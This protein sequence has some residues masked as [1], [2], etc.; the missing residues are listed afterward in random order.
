MELR[1]AVGRGTLVL[2]QGDITRESTDAIANAANSGFLGGGGVD[3]AIH[4]A[5][6]RGLLEACREAK[7]SLPG[8]RLRTGGTIITPGFS[9][10]ARHVIHCVGPIYGEVG[11]DDA[12]LL[13]SCYFEALRL[14]RENG[15]ES[16]AFPSISTGVHGYP[17]EEAAPIALGEVKRALEL[18]DRPREVRFALF[19][20]GTFAAYEEAARRLFGAPS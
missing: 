5:A 10:K 20:A 18:G 2:L 13:A 4:R 14:C 17:V 1:F 7:K 19:D 6:G 9:L 3:G 16:I 8:G 11:G 15:L 12:R